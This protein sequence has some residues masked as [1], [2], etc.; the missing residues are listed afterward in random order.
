VQ[1]LRVA[2]VIDEPRKVGR[3]ILQLFSPH[4]VIRATYHCIAGLRHLGLVVPVQHQ[5]SAAVGACTA[6]LSPLMA[7]IRAHVPAAERRSWQ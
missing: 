7:L 2:E 1:A 5:S 6:T 3:D 4:Q